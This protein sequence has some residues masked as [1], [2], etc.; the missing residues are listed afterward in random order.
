MSKHIITVV[1]SRLSIEIA[2]LSDLEELEILEKECD[3]YFSFDPKNEN[4][5]SIPVRQC[6]VEGDLPPGGEK[7]NYYFLS[8][9][10]NKAIVGFIAFYIGHPHVNAVYISVLYIA[11]KY[12]NIG[13]GNEI[14]N[15]LIEYFKSLD[16]EEIRLHVSLRNATGLRFWVKAGFD[17]IML[18][19]CKEN[20]FPE[21]F[22][23]LELQYVC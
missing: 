22:A 11:E 16:I 23:G 18:V 12:R 9:R 2:T 10:Q 15:V 6:L 19:N 4:N 21:V 8:I 1:T 5:Q 3:S 17:R 7:E 20:L 13:F 14:V